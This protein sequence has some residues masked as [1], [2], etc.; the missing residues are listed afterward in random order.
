[1]LKAAICGGS[2]YTGGELIRLLSNHPYVK[3]T[4][5]TSE[6][7]SGKTVSDLFPHLSNHSNLTYE[8]LDREKLLKKADIFFS[9]IASCRLAER[10]GIFLQAREKVIDLSADYR[11]RSAEIYESGIRLRTNFTGH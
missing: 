8:P 9:G 4:A 2:G 1:M 3:I 6:K 5:V 11:L 10:S 7:S